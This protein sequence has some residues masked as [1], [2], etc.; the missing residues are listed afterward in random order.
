MTDILNLFPETPVNES[1]NWLT[2]VMVTRNGT[3]S[4]MSLRPTPRST[5]GYQYS[6]IDQ[7][8]RR[9]FTEI[10]ARDLKLPSTVP[11]WPFSTQVT[12]TAAI[13]D[14]KVFFDPI[15]TQLAAGGTVVFFNPYTRVA[16]EYVVL[17]MDVDG[18][19]LATVLTEEITT[20]FYAIKGVTGLIANGNGFQWQSITGTATFAIDSWRENT[21]VREDNVETVNTLDSVSVLERTFMAGADEKFTFPRDVIDFEI[22]LRTISTTYLRAN[23]S[24]TRKFKVDRG[25]V[26]DGTDYDYWT[27]FLDTVRGSWK[28]FLLSTQLEDMTLN[29]ALVQSGTTMDILELS[30]DTLFH[31]FDVYKHFEI[32]YSD[33]T[34]SQHTITSS[35][36]NTTFVTVTF[37]PALPN[38][39]KVASVTRISYLLKV[40]MSDQ[41]KWTH[42]P[43]ESEVSFDIVTTDNG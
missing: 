41:I 1:W 4:R 9:V 27:V 7:A 33:G 28:P 32:L 30:A 13:S 31:A 35:V 8:D 5:L 34:T 23:V 25:M 18:A 16:V 43:L 14:S 10:F 6:V 29:T 22:G 21:T 38:D 3:E 26:G 20:D 24:G 39:A 37:D 40:R 36:D 42:F 11:V 17:S 2:D 19:Q 15:R 12:A